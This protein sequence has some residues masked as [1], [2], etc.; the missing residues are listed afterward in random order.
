MHGARTYLTEGGKQ[1]ESQ[2][3]TEDFVEQLR[4][5]PQTADEVLGEQ[6][7][8]ERKLIGYRLRKA[9]PNGSIPGLKELDIW[10]DAGTREADHVDISIQEPGKPAH[11]M[12]IQNIR[13]GAAVNRSLFDL[14]P[15]EGYTAIAIPS[16]EAPTSDTATAANPL[17]LQVHFAHIAPL[18]AVVMPM[19]GPYAQTR[20]ALEAVESYLKTLGVSP[21]GPPFGR[22]GS[23]QDWDAGYPVPPGTR[24]DAPFLLVSSPG[25]LT[26][27]AVVNGTWAT[28]SGPRWAAFLKSVL[29]QG[30]V[31]A[32]PPM[33]TWSG[34][35]GRPET[36]STE[37]QMPVTKAK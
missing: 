30:Y 24:V 10:I 34:A 15:P 12:H 37:M 27:S 20:S 35:D 9:P 17:G 19:Q 6:W 36:Q 33:E 29:E 3:N 32:G 4:S 7:T 16:G 18:T 22:Y 26:A 25:R 28:D 23:E 5:L 14:T 8:G 2:A 21:V 31:P 11:Q 1:V 13:A